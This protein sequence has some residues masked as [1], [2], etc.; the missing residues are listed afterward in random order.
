MEERRKI[1]ERLHK[2]EQEIANLEDRL[3]T[4]RVYVQ[5]LQDIL[6]MLDA[7]DGGDKVL[8]A[9][10]AVA[11]ARDA[12]LK[13]GKPLH[14]TTILES[15]GRDASREGRSSLTSSLAAYVRRGEIFTR[16]APN[17]FGLSD[18]GHKTTEAGEEDGPPEG[19]GGTSPMERESPPPP[20]MPSPQPR[21]AAPAKPP[22]KQD[23][24]APF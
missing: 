22:P 15:L 4:A 7:D 3:R 18:L 6:K 23:D 13:A 1:E 8:K 17:T 20:R 12:I 14:V 2:K 9:G 19:F 5:A 21:P 24:D 16:P 10:S 11:K